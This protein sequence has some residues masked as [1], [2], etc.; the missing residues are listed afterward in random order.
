MAAKSSGITN[1]YLVR[2]LCVSVLLLFMSGCGYHFSGSSGNRLASGQSLWVS[3]IGI[4]IDS[5]S[6]QTALRRSLLEESHA[7]RG[8][9]PSANEASADL[10]VTGRL[11]AYSAGAV[12][13]STRDLIKEYRLSIAV[14]LELFR[15]GQTT[16]FWKGTL[17]SYQDYPANTDLALQRSAE[18]AA[19]AAASRI[20]AQKFLTAVE[21]SY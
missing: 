20:L 12:S 8:L 21:Q 17:Q 10:R 7:L 2:M 1:K 5:P 14:D 15:K 13:Y 9:Y 11:R 6:A 3:F 18:E 16:P 4:E 19:L